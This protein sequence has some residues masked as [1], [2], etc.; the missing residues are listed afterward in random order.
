LG[1]GRKGSEEEKKIDLNPFQQIPLTRQ[2]RGKEKGK[3][4]EHGCIICAAKMQI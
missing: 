3:Y 1:A 4:S 2:L